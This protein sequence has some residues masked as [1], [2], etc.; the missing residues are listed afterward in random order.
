[1][2]KNINFYVC[3]GT[4]CVRL[5][6][7]DSEQISW[8]EVLELTCF[9]EEAE[10]RL[11]LHTAHTAQSRESTTIIKSP[12]NDVAVIGLYAASLDVFRHVQLPWLT[13]TKNRRRSCICRG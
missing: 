12:D 3:S 7:T 2:L 8:S 10:A 11:L 13:G 1:M 4:G 5:T 6:S 9:H